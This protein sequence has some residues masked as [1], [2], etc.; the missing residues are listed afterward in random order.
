MN[1][2]LV[3]PNGFA[4]ALA[5]EI[6]VRKAKSAQ[7]VLGDDPALSGK[8]QPVYLVEQYA[9]GEGFTLARTTDEQVA[10]HIYAMAYAPKSLERMHGAEYV[11]LAK[12]S[13]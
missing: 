4:S 11:Q 5:L 7:A 10:R 8:E 2:A 3:S 6:A 12:Q 13:R 9:D 1:D